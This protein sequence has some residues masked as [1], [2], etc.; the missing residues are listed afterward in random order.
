M[1]RISKS[2]YNYPP[3]PPPNPCPSPP[4]RCVVRVK[5]DGEYE[6]KAGGTTDNRFIIPVDEESSP[7]AGKGSN[8]TGV[9]T[10]QPLNPWGLSLH[11]RLLDK[12]RKSRSSSSGCRILTMRC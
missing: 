11:T 1:S 2:E 4:Y 12:M 10:T 5:Q 7:Q 3:P 8:P 6:V 9:L